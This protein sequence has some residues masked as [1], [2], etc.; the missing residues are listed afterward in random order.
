MKLTPAQVEQYIAAAHAALG[1]DRRQEEWVAWCTQILR[2]AVLD[3]PQEIQIPLFLLN[4]TADFDR[5]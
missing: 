4:S 5:A 3:H 1:H 2:D